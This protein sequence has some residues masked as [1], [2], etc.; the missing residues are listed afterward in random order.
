MNSRWGNTYSS[1]VSGLWITREQIA[2]SL[3]LSHAPSLEGEN[4]ISI[5]TPLGSALLS[6]Y[7]AAR[8]PATTA[9]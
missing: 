2:L 6:L 5:S 8:E 3:L 7:R 4:Y 1:Q 9:R